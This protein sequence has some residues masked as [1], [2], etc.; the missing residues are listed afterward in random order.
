MPAAAARFVLRLCRLVC[1]PGIK[2]TNFCATKLIWTGNS[3][4]RWISWSVCNDSAE[5]RQC[6]LRS[7]S[8]WEEGDSL[9]SKQSQE[10]LCFHGQR[11]GS[12]GGNR[13]PSRLPVQ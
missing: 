11:Y 10:V 1:C 4:A 9:F 13:A 8:I 3:I 5:E 2:P 12:R 6:R 7:T